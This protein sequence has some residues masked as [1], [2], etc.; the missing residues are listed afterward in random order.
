MYAI[1]ALMDFFSSGCVTHKLMIQLPKRANQMNITF[2]KAIA[3]QQALQERIRV[4]QAR[5][6][7]L[8]AYIEAQNTAE[9]LAKELGL[10]DVAPKSD[11]A[12]KQRN[13]EVA[14]LQFR[15]TVRKFAAG[16]IE[17]NGALPTVKIVELLEADGI[18]FKAK[19]KQVAV[20]Q[21]LGATSGDY[22]FVTDRKVGWSLNSQKGENPASTGFSGVT[23][24]V[25]DV[26][27]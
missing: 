25:L 15:Q 23:M 5:I 24:S 14:P 17:K 11:V 8:N 22:A 9:A 4:E 7:K 18:E 19:N 1:S 21:A 3:E 2:N 12:I 26:F 16:Y 6:D 27:K 13:V 20:S 10:S